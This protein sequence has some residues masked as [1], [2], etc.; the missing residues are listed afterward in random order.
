[1]LCCTTPLSIACC[2]VAYTQLTTRLAEEFY[3]EHKGKA[4][5]NGLVEFMTSGPIVAMVLSKTGA[6]HAWRELMGPTNVFDARLELPR[7]YA[8]AE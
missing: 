2:A 6:I 4:F 7:R 5:F 3:V 1:L 8:T